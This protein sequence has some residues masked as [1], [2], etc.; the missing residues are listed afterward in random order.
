MPC[1]FYPEYVRNKWAAHNNVSVC[2]SVPYGGHLSTSA[3]NLTQNLSTIVFYFVYI[4][5][6]LFIF[7]TFI[8]PVTFVT[9]KHKK[10]NMCQEHAR[11]LIADVCSWHILLTLKLN[12][13]YCA[14]YFRF[15]L[16][17]IGLFCIL[18]GRVAILQRCHGKYYK[19]PAANLLPSLRVKELWKSVN[20]CQSYA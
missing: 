18:Q 17:L 20:I 3:F 13:C 11:L 14:K 10:T 9:A 7:I 2:A 15:S 4:F 5:K 12:R 19:D 1:W 8:Y 6:I 16:F